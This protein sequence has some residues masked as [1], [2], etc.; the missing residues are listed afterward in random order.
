M[1]ENLKENNTINWFPGHMSK[2]RRLIAENLKLCDMVCEIIDARIP[3]ASRNP[4]FEELLG[5]KPRIVVLNKSDLSDEVKN[6][7]WADY[8]KSKGAFCMLCDSKNKNSGAAFEKLCK[9]AGADI[10]EKR[11]AKGITTKKLRVMVAGIPNVGKSTFINMLAGRKVAAAQDKPGVTKGKQ[12]ITVGGASDLELLDM[13]GMLWPKIET[14]RQALLLCYTGAIKDTITDTEHIA[15][16]LAVILNNKYR[17]RLKERYKIETT[18][19]TE[20][21]ELLEKIG[22]A[23]GFVKKGSVVDTERTS[24]ILIDEYRAGKLG[25]ITLEDARDD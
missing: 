11:A 8:F 7:E 14:H 3:Q 12:W 22:K 16:T 5:S 17:D 1:E 18:D 25:R 23:R 15:G 19:E 20:P 24:E 10:L 2:T 21:H 4:L 13:P 6:K 9:T